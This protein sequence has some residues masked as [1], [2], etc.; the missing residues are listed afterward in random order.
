MVHPH[1]MI[2]AFGLGGRERSRGT[3]CP[4][5]RCQTIYVTVGRT[6]EGTIGRVVFNSEHHNTVVTSTC[7]LLKPEVVQ[8]KGSFRTRKKGSLSQKTL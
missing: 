7:I 5:L 3:N 8:E 6:G 2:T 1:D 4:S